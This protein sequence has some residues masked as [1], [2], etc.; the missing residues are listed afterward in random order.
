MSRERH[1]FEKNNCFKHF[2]FKTL[3]F[4]R[5]KIFSNFIFIIIKRQ[6]IYNFEL[7]KIKFRPDVFN[8]DTNSS[9]RLNLVTMNPQ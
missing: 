7:E 1:R 5:N 2:F 6:K 4:N 8:A 3:P 9:K